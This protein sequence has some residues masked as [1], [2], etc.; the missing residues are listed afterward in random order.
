MVMADAFD[1]C[2]Q[3]GARRPTRTAYLATLFAPEKAR[4]ALFALYAFN[5]EWRASASSRASR[6]RA[7]SGCNGGATR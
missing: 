6:C 7:K 4:R 5:L 3:S 1:H 2:E